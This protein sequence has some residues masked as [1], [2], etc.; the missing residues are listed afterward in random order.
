MRILH[1]LANFKWTGPADPAL[2]CALEL[3]RAG[4]DVVFAQA[5]WTLPGA[6]HRMRIELARAGMPVIGGLEL[7][8]H[9]RPLSVLRDARALRARLDRGD[10]DVLHSHLPADHLVAAVAR[11]RSTRR[12]LLVRSLY[13]PQPP[14]RDWRARVACRETAGVVAPTADCAAGFAERFRFPRE[15]V[16]VQDPPVDTGRTA[17]TGDLRSAWG[18]ARE[19]MVVG[20][21]ARIQAHRRF[22]L[23]WATARRVADAE[24][25]AT[26]VLLGRGNPRDTEELVHRPVRELGLQGNVRL[27]GYLM[28]PEYGR[29]LR[30]LDLFL[31]LVP[32]SDGTCRAVREVMALGVPVVATRRGIL[33]EL[34][35]PGPGGGTPC[36][37]AAEETPDAL[38]GA[39]L[40]L[41]RDRARRAAIGG[42]AA[43]RARTS[44]DPR[45]A[46]QRL[47]RFYR[48]L[49]ASRP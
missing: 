22:D 24:P 46:A 48:D 18:L 35:G 30:S 10:F 5:A 40:G 20:V 37:V 15:R 47:L 13:D 27:P 26:F 41:W 4:A 7:R 16:L 44:M 1:L 11:R 36:G 12:P 39:L 14:A 19:R 3:R 23:L 9:F 2:R 25:G 49:A 17:G 42:A 21:T 32:G 8:K 29:A 38:A 34:L 28:D 33:P 6:E 45:A 31:F 43:T